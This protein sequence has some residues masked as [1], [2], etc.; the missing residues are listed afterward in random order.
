MDAFKLLS[1]S[2]KLS[3]SKV[4]APPT[5]PS[6]GQ[7]NNPQLF[8]DKKAHSPENLLD[9]HPEQHG[10]K[11]KRVSSHREPSALSGEL[12]FFAQRTVDQSS[13]K[14][15]KDEENEE[16]FEITHKSEEDLPGT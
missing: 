1:R 8:H 4:A 13:G 5:L 6:S 10:I 3:K 16:L 14:S 12:D 9:T 11:R 15:A 7:L 2:T